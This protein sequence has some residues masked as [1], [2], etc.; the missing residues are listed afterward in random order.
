MVIDIVDNVSL[1]EA[2]LKKAHLIHGDTY[3]Y[4]QVVYVN[5]KTKVSILCKKH[6][7]FEQTPDKHINQKCGCP[8]CAGNQK[9]DT[10]T[11]VLKAK[12]V[13]GDVYDYSETRYVN[14]KTPVKIICKIHGVFE[15]IPSNHLEGKGCKHCANNVL[16]STDDFVKNAIK[17]HGDRYDYSNVCYEGNRKPVT[18]VCKDHGPFVQVPYAHLSGSGCPE[19]GLISGQ[20][21]RDSKAI[22]LRTKKT[23]LN[24]YGVSNPMY[25]ISTRIKH[26]QIV[27]SNSVNEKRIAT[28]RKNNSFNTSSSEQ[29]LYDLLK[30]VFDESDIYR[31]YVSEKYPFRCDF[32]IKSR[33]LYIELNAHWSHGDRWF[34]VESD[35]ILLEKWNNKS[36]FYRNAAYTYSI[37]DVRKRLTAKEHT[38]NYVVF[39][40]T[41]LS[42]AK[43]WIGLGCPDGHDWD[44]EY[45]WLV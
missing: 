40:K 27:S 34:N 45:S 24:R 9:L 12:Q 3:D 10:D 2:F 4:S 18:I 30:S 39:W 35:S 32:Y 44:K 5:A 11:F 21:K 13:H 16:L 15:Q 36:A 1:H 33:D 8:V 38:L 7:V 23:I 41:D 17:I 26:K 19:C 42:D 43:L 6:G 31:N 20:M 25:D 22:Y 28:K 14:N 37:R 29:N